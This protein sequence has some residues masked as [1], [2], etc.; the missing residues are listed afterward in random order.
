MEEKGLAFLPPLK[1]YNGHL[2]YGHPKRGY[3]RIIN[4]VI[5]RAATRVGRGWRGKRSTPLCNPLAHRKDDCP[6]N[7][8]IN[9]MK[10]APFRGAITF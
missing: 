2:S 8:F 4:K 10:M 6:P 9:H 3:C 1:Y 5:V 7:K